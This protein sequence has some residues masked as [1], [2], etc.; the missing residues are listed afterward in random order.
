MASFNFLNDENLGF[1]VG[2]THMFEF[3]FHDEF[4]VVTKETAMEIPENA[5]IYRHRNGEIDEIY[6]W[7][8][9]KDDEETEL[10]CVEDGDDILFKML[11][12]AKVEIVDGKIG[13]FTDI[14]ED[15]I[16]LLPLDYPTIGNMQAAHHEQEEQKQPAIELAEEDKRS[17]KRKFDDMS[18]EI[19]QLKEQLKA[20]HENIARLESHQRRRL[21]IDLSNEA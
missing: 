15:P 16:A 4:G 10:F 12:D 17:T 20:A 2:S 5:Y 3:L 19:A 18:D 9:V 1:H 21:V 11:D 6:F 8:E 14:D 13:I 7:L